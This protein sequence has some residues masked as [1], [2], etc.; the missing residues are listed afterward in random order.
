MAK[1]A[2]GSPAGGAPGAGDVIAEMNSV[3]I[4]T[5]ADLRGRLYVMPPSTRVALGVHDGPT[6][7]VVDV[8]LSV[9]P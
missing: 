7:D 2:P 9:S 5:M 8:T 1:V 3:P 6:S 4:R